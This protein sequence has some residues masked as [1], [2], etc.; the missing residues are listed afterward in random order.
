MSAQ[1]A[2]VQVAE[3]S[4]AVTVAAD[5]PGYVDEILATVPAYNFAHE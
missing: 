2:A 5:G 3:T 1:S 4:G